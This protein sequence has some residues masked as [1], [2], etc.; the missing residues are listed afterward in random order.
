MAAPA[1][2]RTTWCGTHFHRDNTQGDGRVQA[3]RIENLT[4]QVRD[5]QRQVDS[6]EEKH[7]HAR[8]ALEHYRVSVKEQRE[9]DQRRHEQQVQ[10]EQRQLQQALAVK[11]EEQIQA[12][13]ETTRLFTDL[14]EARKHSNQL[15]QQLR[16][17][18]CENRRLADN[19]VRLEQKAVS[20]RQKKR[21]LRN[22]NG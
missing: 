20:M 17:R 12:A 14:T 10:A 8:E 9:Q 6:L 5:K 13:R 16:G 11:R 22:N 15:G 2:S 18:E 7:G 4:D 1:C 3:Q 21:S 19:V